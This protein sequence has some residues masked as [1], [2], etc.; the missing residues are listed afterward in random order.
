MR[1]KRTAFCRSPRRPTGGKG[2]MDAAVSGRRRL[3]S[4][5][6]DVEGWRDTPAA[7]L[8]L[9]TIIVDDPQDSCRAWRKAGA[10]HVISRRVVPV[11]SAT[12]LLYACL[13]LLFAVGSNTPPQA[14][15]AP[16]RRGGSLPTWSFGISKPKACD[17]NSQAQRG[18]LGRLL[19][20]NASRCARNDGRFLFLK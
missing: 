11:L 14:Q 4:P 13:R 19:R 2:G 7:I 18:A 15:L 3:G 6:Q 12:R 10:K 8:I 9:A 20:G 1:A 5:K 17:R 16:L